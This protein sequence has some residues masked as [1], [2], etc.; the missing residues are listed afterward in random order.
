MSAALEEIG[1][2]SA[3]HQAGHGD[4]GVLEFIAERH[5]KGIEKRFD[6]LYTAWNVPGINPAIEPVMRMRPWPWPRIPLRDLMDQ[7][8][9]PVDVGVHHLQASSRS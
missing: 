8:H 3:R 1:F 6:P 2:G 9:R 7:A 4:A 5:G